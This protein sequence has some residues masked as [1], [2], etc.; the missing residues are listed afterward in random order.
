MRL[1]FKLILLVAMVFVGSVK[2]QTPYYYQLKIF[3]LKGDKQLATVENYL[4]KAYLPALHRY[5]IK[6]VGVF[7]PIV[8][9]TLEQLIYV[10]IPAKDLT[11][12]IKL[13]QVVSEDKSFQL[14]GKE[15]LD[16]SYSEAPYLR[17]E[18]ILMKAFR[19][20]PIP[21]V[22]KLTSAK[23]ERVYELRSYEAATEKLSANKIEMFNDAEITI[24]TNLNF[25]AIFYGQVIAGSKMPNLMYLTA[26]NNKADRD[27]HWTAFGPEYK[28]ISGL[29]QYQHNVSKNT[30]IFVRPTDY[31]DY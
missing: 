29:P 24:F 11:K 26:F 8:T 27:A 1:K 25:N 15:Y 19:A 3:H 22:P 6:Q 18:L 20:S 12:L 21:N 5:G 28:K 16:A 30:A 13:D 23:N 14:D 2:A 10:L 31:S 9:D 7:K 17:I 4:S